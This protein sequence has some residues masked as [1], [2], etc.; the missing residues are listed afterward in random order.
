MNVDQ[1]ATIALLAASV[2]GACTPSNGADAAVDAAT[3]VDADD[4][5]ARG[6]GAPSGDA[7]IEAGMPSFCSGPFREVE[8]GTVRDDMPMVTGSSYLGAAH[9]GGGSLWFSIESSSNTGSGSFDPRLFEAR[10]WGGA[11]TIQRAAATLPRSSSIRPR[12]TQSNAGAP[13]VWLGAGV[14]D[15]RT[16]VAQQMGVAFAGAHAFVALPSET[17]WLDG[18]AVA[19][20]RELV[21]F[22]PMTVAPAA[23]PTRLGGLAL[24]ALPEGN[25]SLYR[26]PNG[27]RSFIAINGRQFQAL[28]SMQRPIG[29][30][31]SFANVPSDVAIIAANS[32]LWFMD[33]SIEGTTQRAELHRINN[34]G[35]D[36]IVHRV[37]ADISRGHRA[38]LLSVSDAMLMLTVDDQVELRDPSSGALLQRIANARRGVIEGES[39][40]VIGEETPF[41]IVVRGMACR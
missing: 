32:G 13:L 20:P 19:N 39:L 21:R 5:A 28:D 15:V 25:P 30:P 7:E 35:S 36:S 34:D 3:A 6:D 18:A 16:G 10:G 33:E 22:A 29:G 31:L 24:P 27:E 23:Q 11:V 26:A 4:A 17:W 8:R 12:Y 2:A 40:Y 14:Y 1:I 9:F 41:Q 38:Q 37:L